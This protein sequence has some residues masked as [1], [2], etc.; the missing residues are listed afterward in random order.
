M[1]TTTLTP[2]S[3]ELF[4]AL[5]EDAGNWSGEPLFGGNFSVSQADKGNLTDLK[6]KGLVRTTNDG[7]DVFVQF[8][9]AGIELSGQHGIDLSWIAD[10]R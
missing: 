3:L 7:R 4:L 2:D 5:A 10:Y 6:V 1:T 9:D 8:T